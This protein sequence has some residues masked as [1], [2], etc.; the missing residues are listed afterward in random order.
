VQEGEA[1]AARRLGKPLL[2]AL[3]I[4]TPLFLAGLFA[5]LFGVALPSL[6]H[7][8]AEP[9]SQVL[10]NL[11]ASVAALVLCLATAVVLAVTTAYYAVHILRNGR[12][13]QRKKALWSLCNVALGPL[14]MPVYWY[15]HV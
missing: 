12:L 8:D 1:V 6:K 7:L 14:V 13:S 3:T 4:W 2:G 10:M 15:L 11:F 5:W 9:L